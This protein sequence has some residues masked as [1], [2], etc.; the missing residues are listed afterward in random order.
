MIDRRT[1]AFTAEGTPC[2]GDLFLPDGFDPAQPRAAII[3]GHGFT[4][5]R[6]S[7]VE[8]G[9]LFA[10]SG[11]VALTIDYRHFGGSGGSPRGRLWPMNHV[12]DFRAAID[13]L[14]GQP[15]VDPRRIGLWGTSFGGGIV[16]HVAA[17]DIRVAATVA[18]APILD[19]DAWIRSLNRE[20]DYLAVRTYL[21]DARRRRAVDGGDPTMPMGS[22]PGDGFTPMPDDP[23]M[24]A[25]VTDW[26]QRTG[27]FLMHAAPEI[28]I[29]S[30]E[31]V[32]QFDATH[33]ARKIAPR[34]YCIVQL[35]G[36]D[37]YHPNEPIQTAYRAAGEPKQMVSVP[38]DQLDCYKPDGRGRTIGAAVAFFDH[39][40]QPR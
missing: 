25:D 30:Y 36:H 29:E 9:R 23:A 39:Y 16:T 37:V 38:I 7:L 40:L 22:P 24:I 31:R 18:Q 17:H 28:T 33:T 4:V 35:T 5:A 34:A 2:E 8:E 10:E 3:L 21:L 13:W 6:S 1:V 32:M 12:E 14:E 26:Y 15:G 27:D 20:S 19:G 11:Y